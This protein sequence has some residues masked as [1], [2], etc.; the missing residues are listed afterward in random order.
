MRGARVEFG[1]WQTPLALAREVVARVAQV[2]PEPATVIEPT[3][4]DGTFLLAAREAWPSATLRGFEIDEAHAEVA[5]R[6]LARSRRSHGPNDARGSASVRVANFFAVDWDRTLASAAA[7]LLVLG[8]PPWVTS[9]ALGRTG[10]SNH[11]PKR[12]FK[13]LRG[14]DAR[15]GRGNF[16]V[17]EWM[18]LRLLEAL[19]AR[20]PQR[21]AA[22][23]S[24][25][26]KSAVA[27]R[28]VEHVARERWNVGP[29]SFFGVDAAEHFGVAVDAVLFTCVI[30]AAGREPARWPVHV[31]LAAP[32]SSVPRSFVSHVDGVLVSDANA[33]ERTRHLAGACVPEWRSGLKHDC[34]RVMELAMG[35]HGWKNGFAERVDVEPDLV[36]PLLKGSDLANGRLEPRRAVIA[37]QTTLGED[38][39]ALRVRAPR[40]WA[41]LTKHR[42]LL[43][44]RKSSIYRG[45]PPFSIFG[46]GDYAFAPWKVAISGLYKRLAF[47]VVGP[48]QGRPVLFD[49]TCYFL[50]FST[51]DEARAASHALASTEARDFFTA[52][53]FWD[54]KRPIGKSVLQS[55]DLARLVEARAST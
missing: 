30:A 55:L 53:I 44:A 45:R 19:A 1:D 51:E 36:F 54:A 15:T 2:L 41:Y 21:G 22:S 48:F 28:V 18:I 25:L 39:H 6:A 47:E 14:L 20:G 50:P 17:S 13:K 12:N 7:P 52:R 46:V 31:D 24:M 49:D 11:P 27:R 38:T 16:D 10:A 40:A 42:S 33:Y 29:G 23:L 35:E 9:D 8:N 3:C 4:G 43:D 32:R 5:R 26:C 37:P 34:A